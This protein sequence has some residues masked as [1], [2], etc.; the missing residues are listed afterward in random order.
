M[1][2]KEHKASFTNFLKA[3]KLKVTPSRMDLLDIFA[4]EQKPISIAGLKTK[5]QLSTDL[6]TLYRNVEKLVELGLLQRIRLQDKKDYYEFTQKAHHHHL[7]CTECGKVSDISMC[8]IKTVSPVL[9]RIAGFARINN[10]QLEYFGV[11]S[12]CVND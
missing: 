12:K 3:Q 5:I 1:D 9:L 2:C 10:H 6:A 4:H 11:C 7:V 8:E